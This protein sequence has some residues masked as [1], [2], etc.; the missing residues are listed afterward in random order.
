[1]DANNDLENI[2]RERQFQ[3]IGA[4]PL[5]QQDIR[6]IISSRVR[7]EFGTVAK[8]VWAA[9]AYQIILY[10]FLTHTLV[11]RWADTRTSCL[12]LAG[13]AA[14][15]WLTVVFMRRVRVLYRSRS[16]AF[17]AGVPDILRAVE[18][19]HARLANFYRFK[20]RTDWAGVPVSCA[21]IVLVTFSLFVK[22]GIA[23]NPLESLVIFSLWVGLSLLAIRAENRK[24]FVSPLE[25]LKGIL[26][27]LRSR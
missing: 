8:F 3:E 23:G 4:D 20:R 16:D 7:K 18:G 26:N 12:C 9:I 27:D 6:T 11:T 17:G 2:W 15:T 25:R 24:Y 22:G 19:E 10:S 13:L 21:I 1:M 14:C 5:K